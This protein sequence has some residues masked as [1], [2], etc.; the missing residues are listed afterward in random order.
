MV[1]DQL[2]AAGVRVMWAYNPWDKSTLRGTLGDDPTQMAE[3]IKDTG[4][5]GFNGD[6]MSAIPE[7]FFD[8]ARQIAGKPIAME[9]EG[10]LGGLKTLNWQT[11][12][13]CEGCNGDEPSSVNGLD[14]PDVDR[15]KWI[16]GSRSM[17]HWS[18]RYSGS[19]ESRDQFGGLYSPLWSTNMSE[20]VS[21][22][23]EIQ[24]CWFNAVGYETFENVWG[25]W[26]GVVERDG[27]ALR[28]VGLLLRYFGRRGFF[29]SPGWVPH[30]AEV[31]Q[32]QQ[33]V[34]G[35]AW[36]RGDEVVYTLVNR[37]MRARGGAQLL[38]HPQLAAK[39]DMRYYDC[40]RGVELSPGAPA[41]SSSCAANLT[42]ISLCNACSC[43][44]EISMGAPGSDP[45]TQAL[46]FELGAGD[47]GCVL[48][49]RNATKP[50]VPAGV[51][52]RGGVKLQPANLA[53]LLGLMG[54]LT[55]RG[56]G[57]FSGEWHYALQTM[58]PI[59]HTKLRPLHNA[60]DGQEVYVPGSLFHFDA[61]GVEVESAAGSGCDVQFP[62][63]THPGRYHSHTMQLNAMYVDRF[64]VTNDQYHEYLRASK[65]VPTD[66][67]R[68]LE[69]NF[70]SDGKPRAGWG[71]RPVTYV[72]LDDARHYCAFHQKRLPHSYEWQYLSQVRITATNANI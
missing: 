54:A 59:P 37:K 32:M 30:T 25:T 2:H 48:A 60:T 57:T 42:E 51:D 53:S 33:G 58:V 27:E 9:G 15:V 56:L 52:L 34:F 24:V 41:V 70:G 14:I 29:T 50:I 28:R 47:F 12:G 19:P 46:S 67:G 20:G 38:P 11:L 45:K 26:N 66:R 65:Y 8:A 1:V 13:W 7:T 16:T 43:Q 69:R 6:C 17:S 21:K 55:A 35:S 63:E 71:G 31:L 40:Y 23:S 10:G 68:W 5:D 62:W 61:A 3:L 72:S 44:Y 39:P 36:P 49:T 4:G 64:P 22:I 18:D